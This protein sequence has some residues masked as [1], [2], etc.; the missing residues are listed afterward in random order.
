MGKT[1]DTKPLERIVYYPQ[2]DGTA[3]V[4]LRDNIEQIETDGDDG[5]SMTWQ[6]DEVIVTTDLPEDLIEESFDSLWV[7]AETDEKPLAQ[8]VK[9]LEEM[10]D[11]TIAVVLGDI[12]EV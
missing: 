10:L 11:A 7:R 3:I 12:E 2:E 5:S 4:E 6:A 8:R 1:Y 9:E